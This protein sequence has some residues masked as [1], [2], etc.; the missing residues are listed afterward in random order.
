MSWIDVAV[1]GAHLEGLPLHHELLARGAGPGRSTRTAPEYR[2]YALAG[3]PP[4]RAGLVRVSGGGHAI[5]VEVYRLPRTEVGDLVAS[6]PPPLA[7][8]SIRL[9]SGDVVHGFVC[10]GIAAE[11]GLDISEQGGW[12]SYLASSH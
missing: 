10:E 1:V 9:A 3:G 8:G 2:L 6:I 7:L 4:A 12:R 11:T 5:E